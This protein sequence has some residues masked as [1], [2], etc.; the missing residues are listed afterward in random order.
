MTTADDLQ[1]FSVWAPHAGA[2]TLMHRHAHTTTFRE[3]PCRPGPREGWWTPEWQPDGNELDYGYRLDDDP[4][5][6]PDPRSRF[7]PDGVHCPSRTVS[8]PAPEQWPDRNWRG[9]PWDGAPVYELHI[10]TFTPEGTLDSAIGRLDHVARLGAGF[11]EVMPVNA[12]NGEHNWGYD[13]VLWHAVQHSLGGPQAYRR[14]VAAAHERGLGV[15]QDVVFNHLGPSGNYLE[16]FGPYLHQA[17]ANTWGKSVNLDGPGSDEVRAYILDTLTMFARDYGVDGFRLD[18]VH[19]FVDSR[20]MHILEEMAAHAERLSTELG[21]P[22]TLIAE[23]D[24][25]DPATVTERDAGGMGLEA[26]WSDDFHHA[27][28]VALTGETSGYYADFEPFS[29]LAKTLR[30]GFFHDGTYSSFRERHHGRPIPPERVRPSA[31][32]VSAQTHDQVG[33]RAAGDRLSQTLPP[34]RLAVAATLLLLSPYTPMLFMGEEFAAQTPFQFF[35]SHPE[36]WLAEAV[37]AGRREEFGRHG[38]DLDAVPDPQDPETFIRS[39]LRWEETA[40]GTGAALLRLHRH[41]AALR[42]ERITGRELGFADIHVEH[43]EDERWLDLRLPGV[44][45][46][47][48]L[49]P[50]GVT[51][52]MASD[53]RVLLDTAAY[54][55]GPAAQIDRTAADAALRLP[56]WSAAVLG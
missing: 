46:I 17:A 19:A 42:A 13:G 1:P 26:Q 2:V 33:N 28:H 21:R 54:T 27:L 3:I 31:L 43:S 5:L 7:Q 39:K 14:F 36:E 49:G 48:S 15:I 4:E 16:R 47:T 11:V 30:G 18:A 32:V 8:L 37:A 34:D 51:R 25:N 22:L 55:H 9:R 35:T 52:P 50:V 12:F 41:L 44:R 6:L 23:S 10:G 40:Q 53:E 56:G 45:V 20:A 24:R 38:W 29:A